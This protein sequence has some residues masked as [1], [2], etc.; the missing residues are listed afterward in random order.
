MVRF[1][2]EC[3]LKKKCNAG[4]EGVLGRKGGGKMLADLGSGLQIERGKVTNTKSRTGG[5]SWEE[6]SKRFFDI[7]SPRDRGLTTG[8]A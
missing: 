2:S 6:A 1:T 7:N 3:R 4:D 8:K 5:N